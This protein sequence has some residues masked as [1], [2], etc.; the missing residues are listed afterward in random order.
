MSKLDNFNQEEF[1]KIVAE[2]CSMRELARALGYQG[3]GYNGEAI[4]KKCLEYNLSLEHF[5]GQSKNT[6]KRS[7]E[8]VFIENSTANQTTLRRWYEK[9][10]YSDYKCSICSQEPFW[11]GKP[12]TLTLDHINGINTDH[13]LT[14]LRWVCPNCDRQLD[15]FCSKNIQHKTKDINRCVDCGVEIISTS[16][17]CNTCAGKQRR[18][19]ERPD[20]ETLHQLLIEHKGNFSYVGNLFKVTDNCVRKWCKSYQLPFHSGDYK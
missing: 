17:R 10:Q 13:R 14:N 8:N 12:L 19:T 2:C 7:E 6:T 4:K 11:N 3:G 1:S 9:G 15:T 5:T 20:A 16:T 18:S